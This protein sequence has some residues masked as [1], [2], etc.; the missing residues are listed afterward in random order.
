[1]LESYRQRA[2]I[3]KSL[4]AFG[5]DDGEELLK[6]ILLEAVGV[7]TEIC[8]I[9]KLAKEATP[10]QAE[11]E[12]IAGFVEEMENEVGWIEGLMLRL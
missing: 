9:Y 4:D 11:K 5:Q 2:T 8:S 1:M 3:A 7:N 12:W 10:V 6:L